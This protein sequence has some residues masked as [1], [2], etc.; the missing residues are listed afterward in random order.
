MQQAIASNS[1]KENNAAPGRKGNQKVLAHALLEIKLLFLVLPHCLGQ[2][3]LRESSLCDTSDLYWQAGP[4][5][6]HRLPYPEKK[7]KSLYRN[8]GGSKIKVIGEVRRAFKRTVPRV[9][10]CQGYKEERGCRAEKAASKPH[11][12]IVQNEEGSPTRSW[13]LLWLAN[14]PPEA[15][16]PCLTVDL[17][18]LL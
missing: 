14:S 8:A 6:M 4:G 9:S 1:S 12:H 10:S 13:S 11:Q 7:K 16:Q 3:S 5:P 2:V 15:F 18:F 17:S